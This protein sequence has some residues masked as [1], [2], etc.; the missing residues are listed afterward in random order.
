ME[1][2]VDTRERIV[3]DFLLKIDNCI[4][5]KIEQIH[6][7]D[8]AIVH[9]GKIVI[10]IE[11]KT[12]TDLAA[13]MYDGRKDNV[14]KLIALRKETGCKIMYLIE[15]T[16]SPSLHTKYNRIP[17]LSLQ[18]HL[19]HIMM[20]DDIHI[21]Q[22]AD[23]KG[24]AMRLQSLSRNYLSM[25]EVTPVIKF[26]DDA[27]GDDISWIPNTTK[28]LEIVD[29]D[30]NVDGTVV[31]DNAVDPLDILKKDFKIVKPIQEYIL[32][33]VKGI[34]HSIAEA[35]NR[36]KITLRIL[37]YE[38]KESTLAE[39]KYSNKLYKIGN[40]RAKTILDTVKALDDNKSPD[41]VNVLQA[42]A[43][44][45]N[46]AISI[47]KEI[48]LSMILSGTVT[49]EVVANIKKTPKAKVGKKTAE[50]LFNVLKM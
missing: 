43:L 32:S 15:G 42:C 12:W 11:R 36:E 20:R 4:K 19:D 46:A 50:A 9:N 16:M 26:D 38:M 22:T 45:E 41:W 49:T 5:F 21:V 18:A 29:H 3:I 25:Y 44:S 28:C 23:A 6:V 35:L 14:N 8:Y 48:T 31:D 40:K 13:S 27:L 33:A 1:I 47:S 39:I 7:G 37:F 2:I 24:T 34:G 10:I 30:N 17:F